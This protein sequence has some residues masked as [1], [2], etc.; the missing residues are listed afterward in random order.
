M[1]QYDT[2]SYIRARL[3]DAHIPRDKRLETYERAKKMLPGWRRA[4]HFKYGT[5]PTYGQCLKVIADYVGV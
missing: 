1:N 3:Y 5:M 4:A 2:A